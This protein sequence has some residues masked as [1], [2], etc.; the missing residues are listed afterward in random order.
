MAGLTI[1]AAGRVI[2]QGQDLTRMDEA[3]R[4]RVRAGNIGLVFQR[5][6]LIPFLNAEE[7]VA[8]A[9]K[10]AGGSKATRKARH[11]MRFTP[12]RTAH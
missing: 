8:M 10:L 5:G 1:P 11:G 7:N 6:N 2:F 4:A 12:A 9:V 3:E